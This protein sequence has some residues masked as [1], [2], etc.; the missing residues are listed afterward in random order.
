[1]GARS[2]ITDDELLTAARE[3]FLRDGVHAPTSAVAAHAGVSE[4]LVFKRF[5][6]RDELLQRVFAPRRPSWAD[7]LDGE[8]SPRDRLERVGVAM[9]E[10]MRAEMPIAMLAWSRS[11]RDHWEEHPGEPPPVTGMK[12]LSAWFEAQMRAGQLR[13]T[14]PEILARVFSGAI[15]AHAMS[16]MTGLASHMPLAATTFVRG[17]VDVVWNGVAPRAPAP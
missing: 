9:I 8:G 11:P 1:M 4:A 2:R 14:D 6:T 15:V 5:G 12:I 17:L 10:D 7:L 3:V 13:R 16:E